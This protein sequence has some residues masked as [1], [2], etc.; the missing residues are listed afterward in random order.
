MEYSYCSRMFTED[1]KSLMRLTMNNAIADR[2]NLTTAGNI[3]ATGV[4]STPTVCAPKPDFYSNRKFTCLGDGVNFF[5]NSSNGNPTSWQWTFDDATPATSNVENPTNI[6]FNNP[7]WKRVELTVSNASG[8]GTKTSYDYI[9]VGRGIAE[10]TAPYSEPFD[11]ASSFIGWA[12]YNPSN[13]SHFFSYVSNTGRTGSG[14]IKL[15]TLGSDGGEMDEI[16]SPSVN[17]DYMNTASLKFWY[18]LGS[19]SATAANLTDI[20]RVMVSTNCGETWNTRLTLTGVNLA[21]AGQYLSSYTPSGAS[22]WTEGSM[23]IPQASLMPDTRFKFQFVSSENSNNLYLDDIQITGVTGLE[24]DSKEVN[25]L[26]I[27]PNPSEG[28]TLVSLNN[29]EAGMA[30]IT[31]LDLSG[32]EVM[33]LMNGNISAGNHRLTLNTENLSSG[34][35]LLNLNLNGKI[36]QEKL[37]VR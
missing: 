10:A 35:Y 7:G 20:L 3:T 27:M 12:P 16:V 37:I 4:G 22:F 1:Q 26:E 25:K 28:Q 29:S 18:S 6:V 8:N 9:Y 2:N 33:L 24:E 36:Q 14:C 5:D 31:L 21:K 30:K 15:N 13:D 32:R 17:L 34:M 11:N 23:V 19:T